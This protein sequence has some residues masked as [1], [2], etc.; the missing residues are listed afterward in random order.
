M[1]NII[2]PVGTEQ[3]A[4]ALRVNQVIQKQ[5]VSFLL[6]SFSLFYAGIDYT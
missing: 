1:G 3:I 4:N 5:Y 2:G 6:F